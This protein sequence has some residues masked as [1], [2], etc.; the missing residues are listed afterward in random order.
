MNLIKR[1]CREQKLA[2]II[3]QHDLNRAAQYCDRV[4]LLNG[5]QIYAEGIPQEVITTQ[6]IKEVY[7]ADVSVHPHPINELLVL[8]ITV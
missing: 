7:G 1:F 4:V 2:V 3:A 8:Y 5:G 6:N